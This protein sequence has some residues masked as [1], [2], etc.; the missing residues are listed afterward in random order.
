MHIQDISKMPHKND[1]TE[2]IKFSNSFHQINNSFSFQITKNYNLEFNLSR[3]KGALTWQRAISGSHSRLQDCSPFPVARGSLCHAERV[4]GVP[5]PKW[6]QLA[7]RTPCKY[8]GVGGLGGLRLPA[9]AGGH[10]LASESLLSLGFH[11]D[12]LF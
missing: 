6:N 9:L 1:N 8:C 7:W 4:C 11:G 2:H 12:V 10:S 3:W 5:Q